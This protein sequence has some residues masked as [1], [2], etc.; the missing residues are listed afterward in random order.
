MSSNCEL[1]Y[2]RPEQK[3]YDLAVNKDLINWK[4]FLY[5]LIHN[6]GLNPWDI[7]LGILTKRYIDSLKALQE[8]DFD[9]SGKFLTIAVFL[10]KTKTETLIERDIRGIEETIASYRESE[11]VIDDLSMLED[12]DT[13]L[14]D[15]IVK[16]KKNYSLKYRNPIARKRKV[17]IFDLIKTLEKTFEQSNKRRQNFLQKKG[18]GEYTGPVFE[19]KPKDLKQLI[20]ELYDLIISELSTKKAHICFSYLISSK[21][22]KMDILDRFIPLLHLHNQSKIKL[23]QEN[24]FGE[25]KIHKGEPEE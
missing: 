8:V 4:S 15:I 20:E 17:T 23:S 25:I 16:D 21:T 1:E 11:N 9:I 19:R 24:H 5:E 14:D 7:D 10:L 3:I 2:V 22:E 12:F 18:S 13:Q 6:E